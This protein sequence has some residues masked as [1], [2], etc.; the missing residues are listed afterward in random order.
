[1]VCGPS[2]PPLPLPRVLYVATGLRRPWPQEGCQPWPLPDLLG[3]PPDLPPGPLVHRVCTVASGPD[4]DGAP[5]DPFGGD[6][7]GACPVA[8]ARS[9]WRWRALA[10]PLPGAPFLLWGGDRGQSRLLRCLSRCRPSPVAMTG[11]EGLFP[12]TRWLWRV[13]A[14]WWHGRWWRARLWACCA[15]LAWLPVAERRGSGGALVA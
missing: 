9:G 8:V 14:P 15:M 2:P 12:A 10:N 4:N 1:M 13:V 11:M 6:W 3:R 7:C 5:R